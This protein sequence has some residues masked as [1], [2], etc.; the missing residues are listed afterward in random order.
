MEKIIPTDFKLDELKNGVNN[1]NNKKISKKDL[2]IQIIMG[3]L[4]QV[5]PKNNILDNILK[6]ATES[7]LKT[8]KSNPA[9]RSL[10][11]FID[12]EIF[13]FISHKYRM[14]YE[15]IIKN[16]NLNNNKDCYENKKTNKLQLKEN[17]EKYILN[18]MNPYEDVFNNKNK[19]GN[20]IMEI[21]NPLDPTKENSRIKEINDKESEDEK[22]Y[23][24]I[25]NFDEYMFFEFCRKFSNNIYNQ[26][27]NDFLINDIIYNNTNRL[28]NDYNNKKLIIENPI[29]EKQEEP[30][31][32]I[33]NKKDNDKKNDEDIL[34]T[35]ESKVYIQGYDEGYKKGSE[36]GIIIK[37]GNTVEK[38]VFSK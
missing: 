31:A 13:K 6:P 7:I 12:H 18:V 36:E 10:D 1:K 35:E 4:H 16:L 3:I 11:L 27:T 28:I 15:T 37:G 25:K 5:V 9:I 21:E 22:E 8:F 23:I 2:K 29:P 19:H 26:F 14:I 32:E 38:R 30:E 33:Q 24:I 34:N 17:F 20:L